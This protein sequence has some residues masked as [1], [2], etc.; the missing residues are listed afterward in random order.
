MRILDTKGRA[1]RKKAAEDLRKALGDCIDKADQED[2]WEALDE[3]L[4]RAL[5]ILGLGPGDEDS[6]TMADILGEE[7]EE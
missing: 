7:D 4:Q 1:A 5:E 2:A 6:W 3:P